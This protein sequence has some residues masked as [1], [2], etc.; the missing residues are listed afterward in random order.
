MYVSLKARQDT[1]PGSVDRRLDRDLAD[2]EA[3]MFSADLQAEEIENRREQILS[4][5]EAQNILGTPISI[6][7]IVQGNERVVIL[8]DPGSGKSTFLRYIALLHSQ[9][10]QYG[11]N[12]AGPLGKLSFPIFIRVAEYVQ[13]GAWKTQALSDYLVAYH[14][15]FECKPAGLADLLKT[16]LAN[17]NCIILLDGLDEIINADE[18]RG[19]VQQI[20][21]FVRH[22]GDRI[23]NP[24]R[25]VVT[26]RIAGYRNAPIG[27][28]FNHFVIEEMD[29]ALITT[30][31]ERWCP[32][33]EAFERP[34]ASVQD[35]QEAANR[36]I[37]G[38]T[39]AVK[40]PGVRR[41]AANPLLLRVLA[42]IHRSGK[43]VTTKTY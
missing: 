13:S 37:A 3:A 36:E 4:R 20:E 28:E 19:V 39:D 15:K 5:L 26:S 35:R 40:N 38:I 7:K 12:E 21:A 16:E 43:T 8:G 33:V 30:F 22:H 34:D 11:Q 23:T 2:L 10:I 14:H 29:E 24:N 25:F 18:R 1:T 17:G 6:D 9:A 27:G 32:S 41:L 31:L 42:L